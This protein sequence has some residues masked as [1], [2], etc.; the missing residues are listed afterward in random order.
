[1]SVFDGAPPGEGGD[2]AIR[3]GPL[4]AAD[5]VRSLANEDKLAFWNGGAV[6]DAEKW[7]LDVPDACRLVEMAIRQGC[8]LGAQ[9]CM[10][11]PDGP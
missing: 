9:W 11:K 4:Y 6:R 3:G 7:S 2:R 8:Y 1:V 5:A 10:Q